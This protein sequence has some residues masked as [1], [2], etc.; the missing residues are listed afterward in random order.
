M[1]HCEEGVDRGFSIGWICC[2]SWPAA[3]GIQPD[4]AISPKGEISTPR[5]A[6]LAMTVNMEHKQKE[7]SK[8]T[9][10]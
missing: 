4:E 10:K 7:G 5:F 1:C 6:G 8:F 2:P 9:A 3:Q